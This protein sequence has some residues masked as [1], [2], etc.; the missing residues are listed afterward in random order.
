MEGKFCLSDDSHGSDQVAAHYHQLPGFLDH[1][2]IE[3]LH[4][5][6]HSEREVAEPLDTRFPH[7]IMGTMGVEDLRRHRFWTSNN[8]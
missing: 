1:V 5:L 4:F 2:G 6:S 8:L 3:S 7:L